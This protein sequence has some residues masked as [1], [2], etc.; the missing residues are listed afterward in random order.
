M[1]KNIADWEKLRRR[2]PYLVLPPKI[3]KC[4]LKFPILRSINLTI[5]GLLMINHAQGL[6]SMKNKSYSPSKQH[7]SQHKV[8]ILCSPGGTLLE[9]S[10]A[11]CIT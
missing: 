6:M 11:L 8:V 7:P 9:G 10:T 2:S 5:F 4:G 1:D 3:F